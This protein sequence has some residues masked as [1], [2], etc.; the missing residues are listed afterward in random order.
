MWD[1]AYCFAG[2]LE[3]THKWQSKGEQQ[4]LV[5]TGGRMRHDVEIELKWK[6]MSVQSGKP[7]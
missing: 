5:S 1:A 7:A 2:V 6:R 4:V 3:S